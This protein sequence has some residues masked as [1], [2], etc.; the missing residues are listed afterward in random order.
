MLFF[1]RFQ[2][3]EEKH[4]KIN[5]PITKAAV[6]LMKTRAKDLD[7]RPIKKIAEAKFRKQFRAQRRAE[8][9]QKQANEM[10]ENEDV[11]E[12]SKAKNIVKLM[13]KAKT[14]KEGKKPCLVVAK[15]TTKGI[16]GRPKGVKGR[17]KVKIKIDNVLF[18]ICLLS[19]CSILG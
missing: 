5:I 2:K 19:R 10:A 7:A 1:F 17:Y 11:P 8:K 3:D 9:F 18:N 16:Q 15:G 6:E 14:K 13:A 12:S 4:S